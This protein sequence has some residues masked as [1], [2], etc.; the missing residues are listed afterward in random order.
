[1]S[2]L[3]SASASASSSLI[4]PELTLAGFSASTWQPPFSAAE[5]TGGASTASYEMSAITASSDSSSSSWS[6]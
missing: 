5:M 6:V 4:V 2:I 1:M 3:P